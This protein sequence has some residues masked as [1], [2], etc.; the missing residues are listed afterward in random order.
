MLL[1]DDST[2]PLRP[3]SYVFFLNPVLTVPVYSLR[4]VIHEMTESMLSPLGRMLMLPLT[5]FH[6]A[7]VAPATP[8]LRGHSPPHPAFSTP[9]PP[10][11]RFAH[12]PA[13]GVLKN[14]TDRLYLWTLVLALEYEDADNGGEEYQPAL[15]RVIHNAVSL[16]NSSRF[17]GEPKDPSF[18]RAETVI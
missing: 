9:L 13:K 10:R 1:K 5:N 18:E 12:N 11:E 17:C 2:L 16:G 14:E 7:A 6:R 4:V 8:F 15:M 3:V